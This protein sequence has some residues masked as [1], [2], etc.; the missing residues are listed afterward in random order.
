MW[1][2]KIQIDRSFVLN[3]VHITETEKM[4][5]WFIDVVPGDTRIKESN[6]KKLQKW[7]LHIKAKGLT[8]ENVK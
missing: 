2:F 4:K 5:V 8:F 3:I 7:D 1:N 6:L